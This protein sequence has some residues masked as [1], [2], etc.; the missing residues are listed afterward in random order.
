[1]VNLMFYSVSSVDMGLDVFLF[2]LLMVDLM[3]SFVPLIDG[4]FDVFLF[5]LMVDLMFSICCYRLLSKNRSSPS[6]TLPSSSAMSTRHVCYETRD[7]TWPPCC[8]ELCVFAN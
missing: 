1:M 4:G 3:F 2:S 6:L 5:P 7:E 8:R